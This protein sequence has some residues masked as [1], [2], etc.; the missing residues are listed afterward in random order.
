LTRC[1]R[2]ISSRRS[3]GADLSK[4]AVAGSAVGLSAFL[5]LAERDDFKQLGQNADFQNAWK[6]HSPHQPIVNNPQA[7]AIRQNADI[8]GPG[9]GISSSPIWMIC[10]PTC[11]PA[12][13][14]N[15]SSEK[16]WADGIST[17]LASLTALIQTRAQHA[18]Q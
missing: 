15:S 10:K 9:F 13:P 14:R 6:S 11:R 8:A 12:I 18:I 16:S 5:S 4:P 1:R 2:I 7:S 17:S 3:C